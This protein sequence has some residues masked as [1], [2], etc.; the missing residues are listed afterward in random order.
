MSLGGR[1][2]SVG[3]RARAT[4]E[5]LGAAS[6]TLETIPGAGHNDLWWVGRRRYFEALRRFVAGAVEGAAG[7]RGA[8]G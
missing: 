7:G 5:R 3:D 1:G 2:Q 8:A 4:L 6:R